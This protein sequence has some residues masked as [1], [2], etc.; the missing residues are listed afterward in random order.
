MDAAWCVHV[1][2]VDLQL[3]YFYFGAIMNFK[4]AMTMHA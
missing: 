1:S 2:P 3:G 4:S